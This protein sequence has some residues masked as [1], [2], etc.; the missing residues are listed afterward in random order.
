MGGEHCLAYVHNWNAGVEQLYL[1]GT[2]IGS[3]P[4]HVNPFTTQYSN[5]W[6]GRSQF[7]HDPFYSGAINELRTYNGALTGAQILSDYQAGAD[8]VHRRAL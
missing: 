6:I 7:S 3:G 5:F 2:L 4:A 1:D 8:V